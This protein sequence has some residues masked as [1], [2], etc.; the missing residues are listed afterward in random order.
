MTIARLSPRLVILLAAACC[1]TVAGAC[2]RRDR[3]ARSRRVVLPP[4][5]TSWVP[6]AVTA[7]KGVPAD[8][9][10]AAIA[11]RLAADKPRLL[12]APAWKRASNLYAR[13]T[14][15]PLWLEQRGLRGKRTAAL[16]DAVAAAD[17]DALELSSFPLHDLGVALATV[18]GASAPTAQQLANADVLLTA[19]FTALGGDY[20]AGQIDP[21]RMTQDWHMDT[22]EKGVDSVLAAVI[23]SDDIRKGIAGL[24]P[25]ERDYDSLRVQLQRF[26]ALVKSGGWGTV[27][28]GRALHPGDLEAPE[29]LNALYDRLLRESLLVAT[30]PRPSAPPPDTVTRDSVAMDSIGK[31]PVAT[32]SVARTRSV[33]PNGLVY[34]TTLAGGVARF[35]ATHGIGVDSVL[36]PETIE[37]LNIT[38]QY[39]LGQIAANLERYRWLPRTLGSRYILVNVPAFRL[40]GYDSGEVAIEMKVIVGADYTDRNTPVFSDRMEYVVFRPYWNVTPD[41][42]RK[43]LE[44]K[45]AEDP[46]FMERNDYEYWKD[47]GVTRIRQTPGPRNSLG[48]AKFIFPNSFNIYLHDT[49]DDQLFA[50]D[51]RAFSHGCIRL[52]KPAELA[53]WVLG[54]S[55]DSVA[56]AMNEEPN[57]KRAK[58]K[59]ELPVFIVYFTAFSGDEG[60]RFGNDLYSRDKELVDALQAAALPSADALNA[61]TALQQLANQIAGDL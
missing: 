55:A 33:A 22:R 6:Q 38:A 34:D 56:R 50:K 29:R 12:D 15:S 32:D 21:R 43:E 18:R 30:A 48:L 1:L 58:L 8:S 24:R 16:L 25:Q 36:G 28:K 20:L 4:A 41:I 3:R 19:V 17:S 23:G 52:E 61:A 31:D 2:N 57:D 11:A 44:P 40:E 27:P 47:G 51:V 39:R 46:G 26:R 49:P 37:A 60:L 5:D 42:Q 7:V 35:Q 54:W 9:L 14:N 59:S 10:R 45:I 53:Q 13:F